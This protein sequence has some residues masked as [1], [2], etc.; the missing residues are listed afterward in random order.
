MPSITVDGLTYA[1]EDRRTGEVALTCR[2]GIGGQL[3]SSVVIPTE[4]LPAIAEALGAGGEIVTDSHPVVIEQLAQQQRA[5]DVE[6]AKLRDDIAKRERAAVKL[7][8]RI[9]QLEAGATASVVSIDAAR[10]AKESK[11]D[12]PSTKRRPAPPKK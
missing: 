4:A 9:V 3:L 10:A 8:D 1:A 12:S 7:R 2:R 6:L 5:H 11:P